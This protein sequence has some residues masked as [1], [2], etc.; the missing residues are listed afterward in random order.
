MK[1]IRFLLS[2]LALATSVALTGTFA[3]EAHAASFY[4]GKTLNILT[5]SRAGGGAD[6]TLRVMSKYLTKYIPGHPKIVVKNLPGA[7]GQKP[8]NLLYEKSKNDGLTIIFSAWNPVGRVT[9]SKGLRADY[10]KMPFIGGANF[11]RM[12]Y[13]STEGRGV[14]TR[15]AL[16]QAKNIKLGGNRPTSILDLSIRLS[17]DLLGVPYRYVPGLNPPKAYRALR[18]GEVDLTTVG[19]NFYRNRV[20][21]SMVKTG[22]V[23]PLFYYPAVT[24][25]GKLKPSHIKDMPS[26][27]DYFKQVKGGKEPAGPAWEALKWINIVTGNMIYTSFGAPGTPA[28]KIADLRTGFNKMKADPEYHKESLKIIGAPID[29][30]SVAEGGA[31]VNSVDGIKP[32]IVTYLK[33]FLKGGK[34]RKKK[35]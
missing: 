35:K 33:K 27:Y 8:W 9:K 5:G 30:V 31:I 28:S 20:E 6:T 32:E 22:K 2:G 34:K 25:D 10:T 12:S 21:K 4:E 24:A 16:M 13:V 23:I 19:I 29:F 15:E 17:L 1:N 3:F 11:T 26:I 7:G 18:G 14:K